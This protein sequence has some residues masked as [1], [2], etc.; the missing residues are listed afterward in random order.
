MI[1]TG[2]FVFITEFFFTAGYGQFAT[3][4]WGF[5]I[6]SK[7]AWMIMESPVFVIMLYFWY[8]SPQRSSKIRTLFFL[9]F[10]AHYFQRS[11]IFPLLFKGTSTMPVVICL[12]AVL[13]NICNGT[14]QGQWLFYISPENYYRNWSKNPK[15][16][17][18]IIVFIT[19]MAI[20]IHSDF[21]IRNLRKPG[22]NNH[23]L[24]N[25]G[26]YKYVTSANYFGELIE[27]TGFAI[28]TWSISGFV[29]VWWSFANL[30]PRAFSI[31]RRYYEMFGAP[32][33]EKKRIIPFII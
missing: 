19:G 4:S 17:I 10:E 9:F 23:Y 7:Y 33:L 12:M 2:L 22:D 31:Y 3:K 18:G 27:W 21:V 8:K 1:I 32:V 16:Y 11:F 15:L 24:P 26:F 28:M 13:F 6:P 14:M 5:A 20:N 30:F 25:A 29:F